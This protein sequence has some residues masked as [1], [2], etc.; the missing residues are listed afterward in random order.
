MLGVFGVYL[1]FLLRFGYWFALEVLLV[2]GNG[3]VWYKLSVRLFMCWET[4]AFFIY[5]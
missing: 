1:Q 4:F 3:C 5:I 2:H